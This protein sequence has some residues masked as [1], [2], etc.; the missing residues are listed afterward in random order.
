MSDTRRALEYIAQNKDV[1]GNQIVERFHDGSP[2]PA[3]Y[4]AAVR[5][6]AAVRLMEMDAQA[7]RE[8]YEA[9]ER[10]QQATQAQVE[11]QRA[12]ERVAQELQF[13][14]ARAEAELALARDRLALE[15]RI[16]EDQTR[17]RQAELV[18]EAM[19]TVASMPADHPMAQMALG[20]VQ[21]L[22]P[23][24]TGPTEDPK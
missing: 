3:A 14:Q 7:A 19:R 5:A 6:Q 23:A 17:L 24:L 12:H 15:A 2:N 8:A 1:Y 9:H 10:A 11:A 13:A 21:R 16:A 18:I 20:T 22:M 4:P